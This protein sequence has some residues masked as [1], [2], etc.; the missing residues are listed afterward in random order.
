VAA[1][2]SLSPGT[3]YTSGLLSRVMQFFNL[4]ELEA[5]ASKQLT[6]NAF[7]YYASGANDELTLHKNHTA[8]ERIELANRVLVDVNRR[9]AST[10]VLGYPVSFPVILAPTAFHKMACPE[11]EVAAVRAASDARSLMILSSLSNTDVEEVV[12]AA[13]CPVFFQLYIYKDRQVTEALVHRVEKAGC[14]AIVVTVDAPFFGKREKDVRNRFALPEGLY[15]KNLLP[16]GYGNVDKQSAE[17]GLTTY[18]EALFDQSFSWKDIAWLRSI[19]TLPIVIK[20]IIR[21]DDALRARDHGA[22]AIVVSNHGGRQL[23]TAPASI[24]ALPPIAQALQGSL[25]IW[26]DGGVRRGTD[27]I[28]ALALG[29]KTVCIGRPIL[30]GLALEGSAGA[31]AVLEFLRREFD[32]A[33]ALTGCPDVGSITPDLIFSPK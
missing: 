6:K 29:A 5:L 17:S 1:L 8:F 28:K 33:M 20:G 10:T 27:I 21:V 18:S 14:K 11:G 19:T 30:W 7:D 31:A 32:L 12:E 3:L 9:D 15:V 24:D 13:R 25:E 2:L 26:M 4:Q 23:D 16:A 22:S